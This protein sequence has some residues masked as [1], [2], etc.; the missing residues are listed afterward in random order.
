MVDVLEIVVDAAVTASL[1]GL[2]IFVV[3]SITLVVEFVAIDM[4]ML[5]SKSS[6]PDIKFPTMMIYSSFASL[7]HHLGVSMLVEMEKIHL[8]R[9]ASPE[10]SLLMYFCSYCVF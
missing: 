7:L 9:P 2:A 6:S 5:N 4:L 8:H 3:F 1:D 10:A